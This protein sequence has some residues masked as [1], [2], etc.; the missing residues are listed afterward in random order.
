MRKASM[1]LIRVLETEDKRE[2]C[3]DNIQ[4]IMSAIFPEERKNMSSNCI[5]RLNLG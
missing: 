4:E 1:C 5:S 3:R 2:R